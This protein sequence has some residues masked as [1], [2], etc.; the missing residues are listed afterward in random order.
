MERTGMV[1]MARTE[2]RRDPLW[3]IGAFVGLITHCPYCGGEV[4]L[5]ADVIRH[6]CRRLPRT[7]QPKIKVSV[8]EDGAV[9][10]FASQ[11]GDGIRVAGRLLELG[12][13][14]GKIFVF[15]PN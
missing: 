5:A 10:I 6:F 13:P 7:G 11:R 1:R 9:L 3:W 12:I 4:D 2:E 8:N 15:A 14:A